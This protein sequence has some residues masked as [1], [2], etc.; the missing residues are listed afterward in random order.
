MT[1]TMEEVGLEMRSGREGWGRRACKM[2]EMGA[3][4]VENQLRK[5]NEEPG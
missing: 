2:S 4:L 3:R 1:I 5:A